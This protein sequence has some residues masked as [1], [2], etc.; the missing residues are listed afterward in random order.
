M[1]ILS[2]HFIGIRFNSMATKQQVLEKIADLLKDIN[3]QFDD[4]ERDSVAGDGLKADLFEATVNYFAANVAVYNKLEKADGGA[5]EEPIQ[6]AGVDLDDS[7]E[8]DA[9]TDIA[10]ADVETRDSE[11]IVFTPGIEAVEAVEPPA[12]EIDRKSTRLNSSH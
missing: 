5:L 4:L 3:N 6:E 12:D 9:D 1:L 2:H 11:E 8:V 10:G 7:S